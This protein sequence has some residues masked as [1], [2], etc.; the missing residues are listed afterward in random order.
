MAG[1]LTVT[2][3][4]LIAT[5]DNQTKLYGAALPALTGTLAGVY[6]G[7]AITA[8]FTTAATAG[9]D[10]GSHAIIP[11]LADPDHKLSN[12][13]VTLNNGA[14]SVTPAPLLITAAN[15]TRPYGA[16]NP[17]LTGTLSGVINSDNITGN[18]TTTA[19]AVS[20][21]GAYAIVPSLS[22]PNDKLPNYAVT[23]SNGIL[24]IVP[25]TRPT[26]ALVAVNPAGHATLRVTSDSNE[27][28]KIQVTTDLNTWDDLTTLLNATGTI[29]Y[30][31]T[32]AAGQAH[33]FYRAVLAPE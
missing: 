3:Y 25:A 11:V 8:T 1:T 31:D 7:D 18:Y 21:V 17:V 6:N 10:V 16:A 4:A 20:P 14:L 12:Y 33:R 30:L 27:R 13:T 26:I 22:D 19:S 29:D 32:A 2:P 15:K 9:S 24:T 28:V 23:F 5:A